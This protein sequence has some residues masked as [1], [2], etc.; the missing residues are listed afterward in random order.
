VRF[1]P[2]FLS[3]RLDLAEGKEQQKKKVCVMAL[4]PVLD[5]EG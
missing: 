3:T 1:T 5:D 4:K 2:V